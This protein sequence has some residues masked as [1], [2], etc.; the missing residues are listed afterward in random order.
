MIKKPHPFPFYSV[1]TFSLDVNKKFYLSWAL[2]PAI[3]NKQ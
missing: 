2:R 1:A 3:L